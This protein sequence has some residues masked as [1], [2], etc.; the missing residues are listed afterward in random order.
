MRI[1][2]LF[3]VL[4][5]LYSFSCENE[6]DFENIWYHVMGNSCNTHR[7]VPFLST[8]YTGKSWQLTFNASM[9]IVAV[10]GLAV[11]I[12][13][14]IYLFISDDPTKSRLYFDY[15]INTSC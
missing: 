3:F 10:P 15:S 1:R 12:N 9:E 5:T 11:G 8:N 6:N 13:G 2:L 7:R 4:A 14:D